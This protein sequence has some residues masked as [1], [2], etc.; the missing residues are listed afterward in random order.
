MKHIKKNDKTVI[1]LIQTASYMLKLTNEH[2]Q[3]NIIQKRAYKKQINETLK[4]L[5]QQA[6]GLKRI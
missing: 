4:F 1:D 3:V 2:K 5:K 6:K